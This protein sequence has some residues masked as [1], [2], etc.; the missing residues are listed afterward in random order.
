MRIHYGRSVVL[1]DA[2]E[3]IGNPILRSLRRQCM[4]P[5]CRRRG[6][7]HIAVMV[8]DGTR[9]RYGRA[10]AALARSSDPDPGRWP[11]TIGRR[12]CVHAYRIPR[13]TVAG[14]SKLIS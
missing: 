9:V 1:G 6:W 7:P 12:A 2:T 4:D 13:T 10:A 5:D 8:G 3:Q 11:L 14:S